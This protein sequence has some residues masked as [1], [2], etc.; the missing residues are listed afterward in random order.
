MVGVL[1]DL[2]GPPGPCPL[3]TQVAQE[4]FDGFGGINTAVASRCDISLL[5]SA[6]PSG[7]PPRK[8]LQ[9]A[10]AAG[11]T[12]LRVKGKGTVLVCLG[13]QGKGR[14]P[15]FARG[16]AGWVRALGWCWQLWPQKMTAG[17]VSSRARIA[18][19]QDYQG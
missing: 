1:G 5:S 2:W 7:M 10:G 3:P 16:R 9:P 18:A 4:A 14:Q 6:E 8:R 19:G 11:D 13:P 12:H 17:F 15:A